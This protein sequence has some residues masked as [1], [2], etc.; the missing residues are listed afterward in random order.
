MGKYTIQQP[1]GLYA[2]YSDSFHTLWAYN[3][4]KEQIID[5][6]IKLWNNTHQEAEENFNWELQHFDY[7][8]DFLDDWIQDEDVLAEMHKKAEECEAYYDL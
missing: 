5:L 7:K 8:S 3:L 6:K 4:T 1:N 2:Y